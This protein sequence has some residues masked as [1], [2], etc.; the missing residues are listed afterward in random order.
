VPRVGDVPEKSGA[1]GAI[2]RDGVIKRLAGVGAPLQFIA[3][4]DLDGAKSQ[5]DDFDQLIA[6]TVLAVIVNAIFH[7]QGWG[8]VRPNLPSSIVGAPNFGL[9]GNVSILGAFKEVGI[10][11]VI[12][13]IFTLFLSDFSMLWAPLLACPM[14]QACW[15]KKEDCR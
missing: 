6:S 12:V 8:L 9:L 14:K 1:A 7:L 15:I 5:R 13:F 10:V 11:T 2:G 3:H 4:N